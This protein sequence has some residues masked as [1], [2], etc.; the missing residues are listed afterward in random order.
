MNTIAECCAEAVAFSYRSID[1]L[2]LNAYIPTLQT[3]AA[4][5]MFF[6]QVQGKPILAGKVFKELTERF[7]TQVERLVKSRGIPVFRPCGRTRPGEVA[8]KALQRAERAGRFGIVAIVVHQES[9]R[10]FAS[11]HAGPRPTDYRVKE[12]RRLINHY[13]FYIRDRDYGEGFVRISSY[14][15]F[16]TRVW[17]NAHGYL[18]AQLRRR[19]I[20]FKADENCIVQVADPAA[21]QEL[22]DQ[23]NAGLAETIARHFLSLVPDPLTPEERAAG[24]PLR[25]SVYQAEFCDNLIFHRTQVLNRVYEP[26]LKDHLHLGRLDMVKVMF[27]RRIT[28]KTR[29][30]FQTR[31]LR[32][33]T[34]SCL[35]VFF[36][37]SFLKQYN[38]GG[39]VL[40]TE[41]CINDPAD[42]GVRKSLVHLDYLGTIAQHALTRFSKAQA[43]VRS[44]ALD[45]STF[46]RMITPSHDGGQRVAALRFGAPRTMRILEGLGCAGLCFRAFR[47]A[48]LRAVLADRLGV[49]R[50]AVTP[51]R[52]GYE[53]RK[54]RGKGLVR[55]AR[56]RNLYTLTDLG[57]RVALFFT[58]LYQRL[59][60]PTLDS[61]E[62]AVKTTL[63]ASSHLFDRTVC[64][65]NRH[66]DALAELCTLKPRGQKT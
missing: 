25:L 29:G 56:G 49:P 32:Q 50:E 5:A 62:R 24:Y 21:L 66:F 30:K 3:P 34:V 31:I 9:A 19:R 54:L 11:Y 53:L 64:A 33:G 39:R 65:L 6:R 26:L 48:D 12:D 7:V 57:Y 14:P 37:K 2:V 38:K 61:F 51:A 27:D 43:V 59:L 55:K 52:V 42:F 45:R 1:R 47:N 35:K 36:K 23:F 10:A 60:V 16:Q 44:T 15:P 4:M 18:A 41:V 28:K 20:P 58:K 40:R 46:E 22:A 13:Y 17:M 63:H 8:Q